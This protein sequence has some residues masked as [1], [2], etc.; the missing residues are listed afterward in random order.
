MP[1]SVASGHSQW[2]QR[3]DRHVVLL[4][5]EDEVAAGSRIEP[6]IDERAP[7][8]QRVLEVQRI[9]VRQLDGAGERDC[10]RIAHRHW[11]VV[12]AGRS[13]V[14][15]IVVQFNGLRSERPENDACDDE[16]PLHC[17]DLPFAFAL[18]DL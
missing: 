11:D 7:A 6:Q 17:L 10:T 5:I 9:P 13:L 8:R 3:L 4:V 14:D 18:P 16:R 12:E 1:R 2:K 15:M